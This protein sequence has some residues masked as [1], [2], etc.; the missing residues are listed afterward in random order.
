MLV[1]KTKHVLY[2]DS[3]GYQ[4]KY[5]SFNWLILAGS[6]TYTCGNEETSDAFE[7]LKSFITDSG[8]GFIPGFFSYDLKN[9]IESL[10]S[11]NPDHTGFPLLSFFK[12]ELVIGEARDGSPVLFGETTDLIEKASALETADVNFPDISLKPAVSFEE[13]NRN[14]NKIKNHLLRGD[15]YEMNYC[16]H[17]SATIR[18]INPAELFF[19]LNASSP[20]PFAC[21]YKSGDQYLICSS[22]E[23]FMYRNGEKIVSQPIKG[24]AKR[25]GTAAD[26]ENIQFL[27]NDPKERAENIMITDLVRNDLSHFAEPGSV[28][29]TELC[30]IY[31]FATVF[32]MTSTVEARCKQDVNSVDILKSA[33]PMGSMTG[34][35]KIRAME[36][37]EELETFSRGIYSGSVGY[38]KSDGTFDFNVVIRSFTWNAQNGYLSL[39][40]GSAITEKANAAQEFQEC[41][42]KAAALI[43]ILSNK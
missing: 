23:R 43:K 37:A 21:F 18:N 3:N 34:V 7:L 24:T 20:A 19:R 9:H 14:F 33:F 41:Q 4:D 11:L 26:E 28:K 27:R 17:Y 42:L 8:S 2:L 36:I 40:T 30:G 1:T 29:V 13:Y 6:E 12:P 31:P 32:Q 25:T 38:F 15:I 5:G 10:K 35:P 22:P 39:S 16:I